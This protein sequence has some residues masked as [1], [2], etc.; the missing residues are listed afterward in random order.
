MGKQMSEKYS[1][2]FIRPSLDKQSNF[3][4]KCIITLYSAKNTYLQILV[5]VKFVRSWP[6]LGR[7]RLCFVEPPY[8]QM[9]VK[10]LI[11]HGLDVTEFPGISGW[12]V[13]LSCVIIFLTIQLGF[14]FLLIT[15]PLG[16]V[17]PG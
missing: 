16:Y 6:F 9:T 10:P 2:K 4:L 13:R 8:F 5:G 14:Y 1:S 15:Q 11:N 17:L 7:V 12:L 3:F